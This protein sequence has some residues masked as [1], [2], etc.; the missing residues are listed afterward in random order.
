MDAEQA[1]TLESLLLYADADPDE[2]AIAPPLYQTVPFA[3]AS[4]D[5]FAAMNDR[6]LPERAYRRNGNPTQRRLEKVVARLEGAEAA[7]ATA[8]G[9]G[10]MT[11]T[12]LA[13]LESGDHVVA[14]RSGYGG[15][16]TLLQKLAPRFGVTATFVDQTDVAAFEDALTPRTRL[17]VLETPSNPLLQLTDLAAV[18][19]VARDRGIL[20][21]VDN[22]IAT[23]VDQRPLALGVDLVMHSV[24]KA[25][26]G[27]SD[28]LAGIVAGRRDV[29][30]RIWDTHVVVGAVISP[31]DAWLALRGI[32]TLAMRVEWQDRLALSVARFLEGHAAITRV[33]YPGLES[34]P[35]HELARRQMRGH[36]SVVSF[37]LDGGFAAA[38]A[39]VGSLRLAQRSSS[40]GGTRSLV[41]QPAAM[42][43]HYMDDEHLDDAGVPPGL[44]RLSVGLDNETDL[45]SDLD[46]ALGAANAGRQAAARVGRA[47]RGSRGA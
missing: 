25:L 41:V 5:E 14:Q 30:E 47:L 4:A 27:H 43:A 34:H 44:V 45:V 9:M 32:R 2:R 40:L 20:T 28:V 35:Q 36:G 33:S 8:S 26:S 13:L 46:R 21:L 19:A 16:L 18:A 24:T 23:P 29:V 15:T 39:F 37:E 12:I 3:A 42:W 1:P 38:D 6:P 7:V 31:F 10:A 11:T 17:I 22:T